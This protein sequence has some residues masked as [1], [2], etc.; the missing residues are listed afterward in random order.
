[1]IERAYMSQ[2]AQMSGQYAEKKEKGAITGADP[3]VN[4]LEGM[5]CKKC[6]W[7]VPKKPTEGHIGHANSYDVGRCRRH[8]PTMNGYPVVFVNDWCGDHRIDENKL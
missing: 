5:R 1:M 6:I 2:E 3:W 7:F 8:A 4:R